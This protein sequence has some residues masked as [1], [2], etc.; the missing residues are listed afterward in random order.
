MEMRRREWIIIRLDQATCQHESIMNRLGSA[1]G[2]GLYLSLILCE[3]VSQKSVGGAPAIRPKLAAAG[4][5]NG[6]GEERKGLVY[7]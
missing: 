3:L 7:Y 1:L 2:S 4:A 5:A 6:L